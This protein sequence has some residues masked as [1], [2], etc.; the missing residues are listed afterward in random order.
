MAYSAELAERIRNRFA[1]LKVE[2]VEEKTMMG[3]LTFMVD[4]KMCVGV[5]GETLMCRLDPQ[6]IP[7]ALSR[8]GCGRME[9]TGRPMKGFVIVQT[10]GMESKSDFESWIAW[11]LE[12]NPRAKSSKKSRKPEG[13]PP[14]M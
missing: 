4:G 8:P 7:A 9:F 3:G 1:K 2:E 12:F 10:E 5:I 11:A 6:E 13:T 14:P